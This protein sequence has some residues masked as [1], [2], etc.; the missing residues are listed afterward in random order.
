MV[1]SPS[2]ACRLPR[3]PTWRTESVG[4]PWVTPCGLKSAQHQQ[5]QQPQ[6]PPAKPVK[7]GPRET[8]D[9]LAS[10]FHTEFVPQCISFINNPPADQKTKDFDYKKLSETILAQIILKLDA[11]ET[12]GDDGLRMKRRELVKE[13]QAMLNSLDRVGKTG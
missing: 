1:S 4:L 13:T 6:A 7:L 3:S 12:E 9:A 5:Q 2:L 11:V 8:L 10:R